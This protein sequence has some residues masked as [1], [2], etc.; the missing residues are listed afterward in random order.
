MKTF[1]APD[2]RWLIDQHF[3]FVEINVDHEMEAAAWF[4]GE[5]IPDVRILSLEGKTL[6]R[7]V[8]FVQP[9]AFAA[10][11]SKWKESR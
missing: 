9:P 3:V 5:G 1:A 2:V 7:L 11:L 4:H 10:W 8:G 6:D